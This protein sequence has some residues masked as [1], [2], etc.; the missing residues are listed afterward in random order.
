MSA[1]EKS[2]STLK[3]LLSHPSLQKEHV[4]ATLDGLAET[5][6]DQRE[7]DS[8]IKV[9][10]DL[11]VGAVSPTDDAELEHE[12]NAMIAQ[13][14]KEKVVKTEGEKLKD[15]TAEMDLEKRF[16]ALGGVQGGLEEAKED[17][18][19]NAVPLAA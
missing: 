10:Q 5:L 2:T 12:L 14:E 17:G 6:A 13:D 16:E 15:R 18:H 3:I 9:G 8:A 7:I 19:A 1:Y 11:A 4:E